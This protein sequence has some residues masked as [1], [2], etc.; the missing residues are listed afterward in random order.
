MPIPLRPFPVRPL[1]ALTLAALPL[2]PADFRRTFAVSGQTDIVVAKDPSNRGSVTV[3]TLDG[4]YPNGLDAA[5][6]TL[7]PDSDTLTLDD[8][9]AGT[10]VMV[11]HDAADGDAQLTLGFLMDIPARRDDFTIFMVQISHAGSDRLQAKLVK[12]A[13]T[14]HGY[15]PPGTFIATPD[16]ADTKA[17]K[18]LFMEF[19]S[20][21]PSGQTARWAAILP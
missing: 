1:L 9:A 17:L 16:S 21:A 19:K 3:Q 11:V 15:G 14:F 12:P 13:T 8:L 2:R 18:A 20:A 6:C 7:V 4:N 10:Y 5:S